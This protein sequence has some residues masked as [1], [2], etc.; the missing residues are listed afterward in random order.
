MTTGRRALA[1]VL[2]LS[3]LLGA[4]AG[5]AGRPPQP[6]PWDA[7]RGLLISGATV[8]TMDGA[9]DVIPHGSVLVRD[10]RIVAVWG[11]PKPPQGVSVGG[12]S[13]VDA[14]PAGAARSRA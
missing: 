2:V 13:V 9:H 12:A 1:A 6:G 10:G 14:G 8:V 7:A 4:A 3:G 5:A 11:G